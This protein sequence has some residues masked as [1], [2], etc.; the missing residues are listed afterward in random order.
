MTKKLQIKTEGRLNAQQVNDFEQNLI[1]I[2]GIKTDSSS[3]TG[4]IDVEY[5]AAIINQAE[6]IVSI[7][8]LGLTI[9]DMNLHT[10]DY[11][12]RNK[13]DHQCHGHDHGSLNLQVYGEN[14]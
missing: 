2:N 12:T 8:A 5:N 14:T 7:Q 11:E 10:V 1:K 6:I 4:W 9:A 3:D 13:D